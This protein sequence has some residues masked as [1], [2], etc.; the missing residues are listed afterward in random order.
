MRAIP[1][2]LRVLIWEKMAVQY[3]DYCITLNDRDST[4][5]HELYG[6]TADAVMP[7]SL[8]DKYDLAPK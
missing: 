2:Y 6:K 3:S 8:E 4:L 5:L 1:Y 7:T